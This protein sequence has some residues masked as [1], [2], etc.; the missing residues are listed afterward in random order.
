MRFVAACAV[1]LYHFAF[2]Y[3]TNA[4]HATVA[5][6]GP[7]G[8]VVRYG[9]LGVDLF[10]MISGFVILMSAEGRGASAFVRSRA[11]R[12]YP[13]YW[14]SVL[15][16]VIVLLLQQTRS[17]DFSSVAANFSMFQSL[18]GIPD[19][20]GV[21]WTL[22]FELRFYLLMSVILLLRGMPH[23]DVLLGIWL[24]ICIGADFVHLPEHFTNLL[25]TGWAHYFVAGALA[26]RMRARGVNM[27]RLGLFALAGMQALRHASWYAA[28]KERLTGVDY[29]GE[30]AMALI[31]AMFL[32]FLA[33]AT[34]RFGGAR[35]RL[36]TFGRL[37]YPLYLA[38][39]TVG[40]VLAH[41]FAAAG[42]DK[43]LMLAT[44]VAASL[45]CA[46]FIA[47]WIEPSLAGWLRRKTALRKTPSSALGS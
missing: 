24:A 10:F 8:E 5:D 4:G 45:I 30:I 44:M 9:Y 6:Y 22:G 17:L 32:L 37:T 29:H 13:A 1:L 26:W 43:W 2:R 33:L 35:P 7:L 38:H 14:V 41:R 28:L 19:L 25:A 27:L 39:A 16:T 23:I 21:Y 34:R 40:L 11:I 46:W 3:W 20:E 47:R 15:C 18:L 12:L 36:E 42:V 31:L